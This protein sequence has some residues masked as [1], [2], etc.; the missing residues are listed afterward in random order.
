MAAKTGAAV[1]L[2]SLRHATSQ[3][4]T[5]LQHWDT[6]PHVIAA[7]GEDDRVDWPAELSRQVSWQEILVAEFDGRPIGVIQIID[8]REEESHYWGEI[9]TNLKAIDIWI[10]EA[11]DLGRGLGTKMMAC[12]LDRC[13]AAATTKA[14]VIDPLASNEG[15]IRFY[16]RFGFQLQERRRFGN[17]DCMVMRLSRQ[18][19]ETRSK[20]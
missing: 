9:E 11:Q 5:L 12:A 8:P 4:L 15:A 1:G 2:V 10:G 20:P 19:W 6:Q 13:F 16:Q 17:D 18:A 7:G 3:D 14:V